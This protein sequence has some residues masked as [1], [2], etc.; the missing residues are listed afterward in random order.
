MSNAAALR[1]F[2]KPLVEPIAN[3][4]GRVLY[5]A[6]ET[7][8]PSPLYLLG[9]NPGGNPTVQTETVGESLASLPT[10]QENAYLDESWKGKP[11]GRSVL[12]LRVQWLLQ[13]LGFAIRDVCASNL[14]FT[15]S[16]DATDS[17]YP[18]TA[19]LCWPI[20]EQILR[21]V[22]PRLIVVFGNSDI[23][24]FQFLRNQFQ[25]E[26]I[27]YQHSGHGDWRCSGFSAANGLKVVGMPH[28]SRYAVDRHPQ[29]AEWVRSYAAL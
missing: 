25:P 2:A 28:L 23:S 16:V 29:I 18:Q 14:I 5:S 27:I 7:L 11:N 15:R 1:D 9:L 8:R 3:R 26:S 24:P 13:Q 19:S 4:S 17:G 22:Q 20:H 21:I 10:R 12:Q 6:A